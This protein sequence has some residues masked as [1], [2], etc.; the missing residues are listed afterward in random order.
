M[1]V[2]QWSSA[3]ALLTLAI[4]SF[5]SSQTS[6]TTSFNSTLPTST[7]EM[8]VV[9]ESLVPVNTHLVGSDRIHI[10]NQF[11]QWSPFSSRLSIYETNDA[12]TEL[13]EPSVIY[14]VDLL[15]E[16]HNLYGVVQIADTNEL[17][18]IY[19]DEDSDSQHATSIFINSN[20]TARIGTRYT[21]DSRL[22]D[23]KRDGHPRDVFQFWMQGNALITRV[24]DDV[25]FHSVD[26]SNRTISLHSTLN[27]SNTRMSESINTTCLD[28]DNQLLYVASKQ[29]L[30]NPGRAISVFDISQ[31]HT[32]S[33]L[34]NL[35][36]TSL[37]VDSAQ[38]WQLV[39][40]GLDNHI[41]AYS[42]KTL[43]TAHFDSAT[44][45]F[46]K[47]NSQTN[48]DVFNER[49]FNLSMQ[50]AGD[51]LISFGNHYHYFQISTFDP[52][53]L[54][55]NVDKTV[56]IPE[57]YLSRS[58]DQLRSAIR[59]N[60]NLYLYFTNYPYSGSKTVGTFILQDI[61]QSPTLIYALKPR[62]DEQFHIQYS[63]FTWLEK[64]DV[65]IASRGYVLYIL[66]FDAE[67]NQFNEVN[68]IA[69]TESDNAIQ[70]YH[71]DENT[72]VLTVTIGSLFRSAGNVEF[73]Q[74]KF[75]PEKNTLKTLTRAFMRDE[76]GNL[77]NLMST[78]VMTKNRDKLISQS[79]YKKD[80]DENYTYSLHVH[81]IGDDIS[82][83]QTVVDDLKNFEGLSR[84]YR[85]LLIDNDFYYL[86][87][88]TGHVAHF[89]FDSHQRLNYVGKTALTGFETGD[90]RDNILGFG[91]RV[92]VK[93]IDDLFVLTRDTN[94]GVL[95]LKAVTDVESTQWVTYLNNMNNLQMKDEHFVY[96]T[97]GRHF[98]TFV[99]DKANDRW[100]LSDKVAAKSLMKSFWSPEIYPAQDN[101]TSVIAS[102]FHA[103][104]RTIT[105][106][107]F[108]RSAINTANT[109]SVLQGQSVSLDLNDVFIDHDV[110][111]RQHYSI[112]A[113]P[114]FLTL[115]G[116]VLSGTANSA[117]QG[118][119]DVTATDSFGMKTVSTFAWQVDGAPQSVVELQPVQLLN[120]DTLTIPLNT[121]ITD[122]EAGIVSYAVKTPVE[123]FTLSG[124][125][126]TI[127][128][129][130]DSTITL[131]AT[132][133]HGQSAEFTLTI[134]INET[135]TITL[136][137]TEGEA[138][139]LDLSQYWS[140]PDD[141][142]HA[143]SMALIP[144]GLTLTN[145]GRLTGTPTL[146]GDWVL[147]ITITA[148]N[149]DSM[150]ITSELLLHVDE[151]NSGS[152]GSSGSGNTGG[153]S[154]GGGSTGGSG[155]TGGGATGGGSSSGGSGGGG[156]VGWFIA[157]LAGLGVT[158][159][160][161]L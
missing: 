78:G 39:C 50:L 70:K 80:G 153:G 105:K 49:D 55:I 150:R 90:Y 40:E 22:Q 98:Y 65:A 134:N 26:P 99:V 156:S 29:D 101:V 145:N 60:D 14:L 92:Y 37:N 146:S 42:D 118:T 135:N 91:D 71:F 148:I 73:A 24:A 157:M 123:G 111:D 23:Y 5:A 112:D 83:R 109:I 25:L 31:P 155:N 158:R 62:F 161:V 116:S 154:S 152:G 119:F 48:D 88:D 126:L 151:A 132:D 131:V 59:R 33:F 6:A 10:G 2:H 138:L 102:E 96:G 36:M 58:F 12:L 57:S 43:V 64:Y 86:S 149:N 67:K 94:T 95:S 30:V 9:Q 34:S 89:R 97:G 38:D 46:D 122:P 4:P 41:I 141:A 51:K 81:N 8:R 125:T 85:P 121:L 61:D 18:I 63:S 139:N 47:A 117:D 143:Y 159:R 106:L 21:L 77:L 142:D 66:K 28:T 129:S 15:P 160:R 120:G 124:N 108:P 79:F 84:F 44:A 11:I 107:N 54:T 69:F 82:H 52:V 100:I 68:E 104:A 115:N 20:N 35:D 128:T 53:T 16:F 110:N 87:Y 27:A 56:H 140:F 19:R 13:S 32:P 127:N 103:T 113:L 133:E 1:N 147:P 136:N 144:D 114:E 76:D 130:Q 93:Q 17:L 137:G 7:P 3:L 45:T 72:D 74:F 75:D